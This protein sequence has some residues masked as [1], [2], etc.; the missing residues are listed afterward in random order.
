MPQVVKNAVAEENELAFEKSK[1]IV[2]TSDKSDNAVELTKCCE[3]STSINASETNKKIMTQKKIMIQVSC[4]Q[5]MLILLKMRQLWKQRV[6]RFQQNLVTRNI[7][8]VFV[9]VTQ[10]RK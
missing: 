8:L 7:L 9:I 10:F 3:S 2:D 5:S 6:T 1:Q 4:H